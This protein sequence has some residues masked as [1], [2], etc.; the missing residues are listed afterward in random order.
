MYL[1]AVSEFYLISR[2]VFIDAWEYWYKDLTNIYLCL[3]VYIYIN[4]LKWICESK[5]NLIGNENGKFKKRQRSSQRSSQRNLTVRVCGTTDKKSK[6]L[7]RKFLLQLNKCIQPNHRINRSKLNRQL[8]F[9]PFF[10]SLLLLQ[11]FNTHLKDSKSR[12]KTTTNNIRMMMRNCYSF[13]DVD[14]RFF[15]LICDGTNE[16]NQGTEKKRKNKQ[17][18]FFVKTQLFNARKYN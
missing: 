3:C 8:W 4:P 9:N 1:F 14:V 12:K 5:E 13:S 7:K 17:P 10:L 18:S 6:R 11:W 15:L 2:L 16:R